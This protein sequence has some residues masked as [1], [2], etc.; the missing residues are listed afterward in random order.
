M[1]VAPARS[2]QKSPREA[3]A[4]ASHPYVC[5]STLTAQVLTEMCQRTAFICGTPEEVLKVQAALQ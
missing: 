2:A 4:I 1:G 5:Y 3:G